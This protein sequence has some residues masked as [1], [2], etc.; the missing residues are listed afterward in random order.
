[1][2]F[3][4]IS[5]DVVTSA[6]IIFQPTQPRKV[7]RIM[8]ERLIELIKGAKKKTK[9]A[10]CDLE[11]EM[12]FADYLLANGVI[13]PPCKVGDKY[14][15]DTAKTIFKAWNDVTGAVCDGTSWYYELESVIEDIV[16]LSF[17]AGVL[18]REEAERA[19]KGGEG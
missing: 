11:R 7:V 5:K 3:T 14:L 6:S 4:I 19:L 10:N 8:R 17:G 12:L 18:Y 2:R 16:K 15:M 1:M 13:V 9:G